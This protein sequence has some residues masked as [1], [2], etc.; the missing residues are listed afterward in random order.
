MARII[1]QFEI[2]TTE[3]EEDVLERVGKALKVARY[4]VCNGSAETKGNRESLEQMHRALLR[5]RIA[6]W[7]EEKGEGMS[8]SELRDLV[9]DVPINR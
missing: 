6:N 7:V 4:E 3:H 5:K 9:M 8:A 2:D 1:V